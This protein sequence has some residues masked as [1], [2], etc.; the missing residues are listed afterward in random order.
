MFVRHLRPRLLE[1]ISDTPVVFIQGP[2]QCGKTT[3]A[4]AATVRGRPF[5]FRTFD[6]TADHAAAEHDPDGFVDSLPPQVILEEVQRV[7]AIFPAIKR[8]VDADRRPG[9]FLLTG[10]DSPLLLPAVSESLTGRM[11]ILT[12]RLFSRGELLSRRE[13]LVDS[14]LRSGAF[15]P[16]RARSWRLPASRR[17]PGCRQAHAVVRELPR[18]HNREGCA[19]PRQPAAAP[20]VAHD[21][22]SFRGTIDHGP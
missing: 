6:R 8:A 7:R 22:P 11:E 15:R 4:C 10:A 5:E 20:R 2:R 18:L 21:P 17:P 9:R 1:A 19:G 16:P 14:V 3:L 12:L 13:V